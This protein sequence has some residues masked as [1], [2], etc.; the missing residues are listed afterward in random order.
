MKIARINVLFKVSNN[1][2]NAVTMN[3]ETCV[4]FYSNV[5]WNKNGRLP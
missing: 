4:V 2:V 3:P 5:V 1:D